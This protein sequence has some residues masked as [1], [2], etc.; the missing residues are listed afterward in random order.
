MFKSF[1]VNTRV[2]INGLGEMTLNV[3]RIYKNQI[4]I[5]FLNSAKEVVLVGNA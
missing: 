2:S 1:G 5:V 4:V 3:R